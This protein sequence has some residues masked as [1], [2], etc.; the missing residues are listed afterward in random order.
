MKLSV[1]C[2]QP[3]PD[4]PRDDLGDIRELVEDIRENGI[5]QPIVVR[6]GS[7]DRVQGK[8][9]ACGELVDRMHTGLLVEHEL[10]PGGSM[11][12]GDEYIILAGHRRYA[13]ARAAGFRE[14]PVVVNTSTRTRAERLAFMVRE[15]GHRRDLTVLEESRA[16]EQLTLEGLTVSRIAT[17][18]KRSRDRIK[19]HL[20]IASLP[21]ASK[22]ALGEI[23]LEDAEALLGLTGDAHARA[24]EAIGQPDFKQRLIE[25]RMSGDVQDEDIARE[26][27]REF[28]RP[29]MAGQVVVKDYPVGLVLEVL[30]SV[31]P[32]RVVKGWL[33][34]LGRP[35]GSV[36]GIS[37]EAGILALIVSQDRDVKPVYRVLQAAGYWLSPVEATLLEAV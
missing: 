17:L 26:L 18:T 27:R 13:A 1:Q 4:N 3:D 6:P 11:P 12:A 36:D 9:S 32:A 2:I 15:N 14:V 35:D 7:K 37:L 31:L 30:Q 20:Q 19:R 21:D 29:I 24:L 28:L 23:T 16:Y 25:E 22:E 8:C 33:E 5:I 34:V 10:C